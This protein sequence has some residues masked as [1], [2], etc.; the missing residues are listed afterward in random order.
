MNGALI[1]LLEQITS[2]TVFEENQVL[3]S[4]QLNRLT[5]YLDRQHRLTR[6]KLMGVGIVCGL[7]VG[8]SGAAI[9]VTQGCGV[10]TDGDLL[11]ADE[12]GVFTHF[13][14]FKDENAG[15]PFFIR[16][17]NRVPLV[18]LL[19]QGTEDPEARP[20]GEIDD[21][22]GKVALLYLESYRLSPDICTGGDCDS[23]GKEQRHRQKVLLLAR[24]DL[25]ALSA[26]LPSLPSYYFDLPE[27]PAQR[28][29]LKADAVGTINQLADPYFKVMQATVKV[30]LPALEKSYQVCEPLLRAA[31]HGS[32]PTAAWRKKLEETLGAAAANKRGIQYVYAFLNDLLTAYAEFKEALFG[33]PHLCCPEVRLFPKHLVLGAPVLPEDLPKDP[34][35]HGFYP[36]PVLSN[37]IHRQERVVFLHQRLD[38]LLRTFQV[39]EGR[40]PV[41]ITPSHLGA[42]EL[43]AGA[44]PYYYRIDSNFPLHRRWHYDRHRRRQDGAVYGYF[45]D[46]YNGLP[47]ALEPLK[48]D[49]S[50]HSFFRIE[51]HLGE[52]IAKVEADLKQLIRQFNLPIKVMTLQIEPDITKIPLKP[53]SLTRDLKALHYL[54]RRDIRTH[55]DNLSAFNLQVKKTIQQGVQANTLPPKDV[56]GSTMSYQ[57]F[58]DES[59]STPPNALENKINSLR[60]NLAGDLGAF[61][62]QKFKADYQDAVGLAA[63]INRNV[64]GVTFAS[65]F[66]PYETL[67]NESRFKW[68]EW[69][70]ELIRRRE[71]RGKELSIFGR[72]L[73]EHPGAEHLGGVERG[74]T[75][76]LVY[77]S[78]DNRV[79]ADF[80]LPYRCVEAP[81][82]EEPEPAEE[83]ETGVKWVDFN[84]ILVHLDK[85]Y[86]LEGRLDKFELNLKDKIDREILAK[87]QL[88]ELKFNT[89]KEII[90]KYS[91]SLDRYIQNTQIGRDLT[92]KPAEEKF[93]DREL[94]QQ[95]GALE[96]LGGL[97]V[98]LDAKIA[99]G[100]ASREELAMRKSLDEMMGQITK[101]YITQLAKTAGDIQPGSEAEKFIR[102]AGEKSA[103]IKDETK[104]ADFKRNMAKLSQDLTRENPVLAGVL[105]ASFSL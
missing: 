27:A 6:T 72:F 29:L 25:E 92:I 10:T 73:Q 41:R 98:M 91:L 54:F 104:K 35:R 99:E 70:S 50:R 3:T 88:L 103:L 30:L 58:T 101:G 31:Y 94:A 8:R 67:V 75:F 18:E 26:S 68:L 97:I 33:D 22:A 19:P 36:S 23:K 52:Q 80:A 43:G 71:D 77:S 49:I 65:A 96:S 4:S 42:G 100:R 13:K 84:D 2:Y 78:A 69:L 51:G 9:T 89:Q 15:Y 61:D 86:E 62:N 32:N 12:D 7:E 20:L 34:L 16:A 37:G 60:T 74:G 55:L 53:P 105:R 44:I 45:A 81:A 56:R 38:H 59:P 40:L 21:P 17:G 47:Q 83:V 66:T 5:G 28:V 79:V 90:D 85:G 64:K 76:I 102:L 63:N 1:Q 48:Y 39:P 93:T 87:I 11:Y 82:E 24:S 46:K 14:P 95:A 57:I